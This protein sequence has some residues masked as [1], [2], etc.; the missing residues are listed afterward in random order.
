MTTRRTQTLTLFA[1]LLVLLG[2]PALAPAQSND[3]WWGRGRDDN[4]RDRRRDNDDDWYEDRRD[5]RRSNNY[6]S[7]T[8]R[9][10]AKRVQDRS[11]SLERDVDRLLDRSRVN[12]TNREDRINNEV[13][14]FRETAERLR[15][16]VGDGRNVN[17][18]AG[19]ARQLLQAADR[20][21]RLLGRIRVDSR[22]YADWREIKRDLRTIA[23]IHG[24]RFDDSDN[25]YRRSG[26]YD[27]RDDRNRDRNRDRRDSNNDWWRRIPLPRN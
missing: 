4:R 27:P 12:G 23:D 2:L 1:M 6:D 5:D 15:D 7:R 26:G 10:A 13:R 8:L 21:E 11:K 3:P 14:Q 19:E 18:S 17:R 9:D 20:V 16:R 25:Y 22:T 24:L